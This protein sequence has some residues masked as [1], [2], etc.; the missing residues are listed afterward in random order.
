MLVGPPLR[1]AFLLPN[2]VGTFAKMLFKSSM[3]VF[4]GLAMG[5]AILLPDIVSAFAKNLFEPLF[6]SEQYVSVVTNGRRG[7]GPAD[8]Q[9]C[10]HGRNVILGHKL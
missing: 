8:M 10:R 3:P 6:R 9:P 7:S 5:T 4:F 1:T 2:K